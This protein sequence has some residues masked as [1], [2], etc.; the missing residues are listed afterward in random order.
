M[1]KKRG[2]R[3]KFCKLIRINMHNNEYENMFDEK[4]YVIFLQNAQCL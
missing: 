3:G 4:S 1:S 2:K